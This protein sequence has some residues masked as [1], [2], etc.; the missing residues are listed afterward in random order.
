M[1]ALRASRFVDAVRGSQG[2]YFLSR[3]PEDITV[4]QVVE[5]LDG[6]LIEMD[7]GAETGRS[8]T[9][10]ASAEVWR[11]L[12]TSMEAALEGVTLADLAKLCN[13]ARAT[14]NYQI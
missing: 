10:A 11:L 7:K 9:R 2:G 14:D 1:L 6:E 8:N 3:P 5:S 13:S 12:R 4:R